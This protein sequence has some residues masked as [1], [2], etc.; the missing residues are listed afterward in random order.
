MPFAQTTETIKELTA[1]IIEAP[2]SD[3]VGEVGCKM[4]IKVSRNVKHQQS[5]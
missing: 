4:A 1:R 2:R 3:A 5:H